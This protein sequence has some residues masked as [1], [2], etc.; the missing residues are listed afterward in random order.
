MIDFTLAELLTGL[1]MEPDSLGHVWDG[2]EGTIYSVKVKTCSRCR[3]DETDWEASKTCDPTR[4]GP[5][6]KTGK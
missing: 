3:C 4:L 6:D 5:V 1:D 2:P